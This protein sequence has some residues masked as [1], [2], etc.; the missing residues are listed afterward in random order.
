LRSFKNFASPVSTFLAWG[1]A[2][3]TSKQ[4]P[5]FKNVD[6]FNLV[7]RI[8]GLKYTGKVDGTDQ[9]ADEVLIKK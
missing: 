7:N 2:F 1:S 4:I 3:K 6:V 5:S 8:L 9:F